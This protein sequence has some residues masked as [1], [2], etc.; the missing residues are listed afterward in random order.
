MTTERF[1]PQ[2][3]GKSPDPVEGTEVQMKGPE[4]IGLEVD[5]K[6]W[7]KLIMP[8]GFG[9]MLVLM[10]AT[11]FMGVRQMP[12]Q[13][14]MM[15]FMM[16]LMLAGG[17]SA[18]S[19]NGG[20]SDEEMD[21]TRA[22]Y[23]RYLGELRVRVAK[24][25]RQQMR[26]WTFHAPNPLDLT[27]LINKGWR[28]WSRQK[29]SQET[30][31]DLFLAVRVGTGDAPAEDKLLRPVEGGEDPS[32]PQLG[33]PSVAPA[34]YLEPVMRMW[35]VKFLRTHG[36]V[37]N[38]PKL[39]PMCRYPTV[40]IGGD[41]ENAKALLRAM[42][43][44]LTY[45][46]G[47][48]ALEIRVRTK[49]LAPEW[50]WLKHL[51]HVQHRTEKSKSG[52]MR[53]FYTSDDQLQDLTTRGSHT[54]DNFPAGPYT[55]ILNLDGDTSFPIDG[56][57][58][59]TY[60]TLC[61]ELPTGLLG[62]V[63]ATY[64][65]KVSETGELKDASRVISKDRKP[66]WQPLGQ[67]DTQVTVGDAR[68]YARR[69]SRWSTT[70]DH[71]PATVRAKKKKL[72]T[73]WLG[74]MGV[75]TLEELGP[76]H[77]KEVPDDS[78]ERL[79]IPIGHDYDTGEVMY[80]DIKESAEQG[81]GPH[82]VV[83][84]TTGS[85]KTEFIRTLLNGVIA[86]THPN[87]VNIVVVD[88][89]GGTGT[90]DLA[91]VPHTAAII[92][93]LPDSDDMV[94]RFADVL[95]GEVQLRKQMLDYARQLTGQA[96]GDYRIYEKLRQAGHDLPPMPTLFVVVDEF[97]T[98]INDHPDFMEEFVLVGRQGRALRI[99][100]L[101]ATQEGATG[102][103]VS[104]LSK[105]EANIGYWVALRTGTIGDSKAVIGTPEAYYI[106]QEENGVGYIKVGPGD[107]RQFRTAYTG[108]EYD[109]TKPD[110]SESQIPEP[111]PTDTKQPTSTWTP[112]VG[113]F[114]PQTATERIDAA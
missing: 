77:W 69:L 54:P 72:D 93:D 1:T 34:P 104:F 65:L 24:S 70:G 90:S 38:C 68:V 53:L 44:Q 2:Y 109:P 25:A 32:N 10:G 80:L 99:H 59:V 8:I 3:Q 96:V 27:G 112:V 42:V 95:G 63:P 79:R 61:P 18:Y 7:K 9:L 89:K 83:I 71:L 39:V 105:I 101:F 17:M 107:P 13:Y 45:F 85:G 57:A 97:A 81:M 14:M 108:D 19:A 52:A 26:Y 56:K 60:M 55:L 75:K 47:P 43:M 98:L 86:K 6:S 40:S 100:L 51:P 114:T 66:G 15:P 20:K 84:G 4:E 88:F 87:Q 35:M 29:P 31:S 102:Q 36:L 16:M 11:V 21:A 23:L 82:G 58:G 111:E 103:A 74:L 5:E 91:D 64:Q 37:H 12:P 92:T 33:G 113:H 46:H 94:G 106:N 110:L 76:Q 73:S 67:A 41:P 48:D 62:G 22:E 50:D 28:Q 30:Q 78:P 49:S